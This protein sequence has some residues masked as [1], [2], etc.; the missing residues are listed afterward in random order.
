MEATLLGNLLVA[1][2][3]AVAVLY[4]LLLRPWRPRRMWARRALS[5][6]LLFVAALGLGVAAVV[7]SA[8]FEGVA[9]MLVDQT[10]LPATLTAIDARILEVEALPER[11]WND[12]TARLGWTDE[13]P[14]PPPDPGPG[15]VAGA[16][17]PS[18]VA[19]VEVLVRA[20]VY[21]GCLISLAVCLVMRIVVGVKRA[22]S[23]AV[24]APSP[25]AM[26]EGRI[27]ELE[28]V[29]LSLR[30]LEVGPLDRPPA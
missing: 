12:L 8:P 2:L 19:V 26:L 5:I 17:L 22:V 15:V 11:I 21:W 20:F 28:E 24:S 18:V 14:L 25:D 4:L 13:P 23:A 7:G 27:S 3:A 30:S 29:V 16:V 10:D 1:A 9:T 6:D